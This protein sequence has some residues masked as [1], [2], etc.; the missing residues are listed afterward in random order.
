MIYS[1][2]NFI[3]L[4]ACLHVVR[5]LAIHGCCGPLWKRISL[6]PLPKASRLI[7]ALQKRKS[8]ITTVQC[9]LRNHKHWDYL[10]SFAHSCCVINA[11][12]PCK[13]FSSAPLK[14][15]IIV[16][17]RS[18]F[19]AERTRRTSSITATIKPS[20]PPPW[21]IPYQFNWFWCKKWFLLGFAEHSSF[22]A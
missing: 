14:R 11:W 1:K 6:P 12:D 20:S 5:T 2:S 9:N 16:C 19:E 10:I 8:A 3:L 4:P 17:C 22:I 7:N 13:L 18:V 21:I 15:K